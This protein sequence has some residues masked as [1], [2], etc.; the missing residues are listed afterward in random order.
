VIGKRSEGNARAI[1]AVVIISR[2][3]AAPY[4]SDNNNFIEC[5]QVAAPRRIRGWTIR[6]YS[7]RRCPG[8][9]LFARDQEASKELARKWVFTKGIVNMLF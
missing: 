6:I 8:E 4:A 3:L 9:V 5:F 1:G 2:A 7:S